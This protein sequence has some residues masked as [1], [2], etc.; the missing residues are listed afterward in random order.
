MKYDDVVTRFVNRKTLELSKGYGGATTQGLDAMQGALYKNNRIGL[1]EAA[2]TGSKYKSSKGTRYTYDNL[3]DGVSHIH[4]RQGRRAAQA[5]MRQQLN[6]FKT[7]RNIG[8]AITAGAL[9]VGAARAL[10]KRFK[11]PKQEQQQA[12]SL[13]RD[14]IYQ[15]NGQYDYDLDAKKSKEA[16][17]LGRKV[18]LHGLGVVGGSA[19]TGHTAA[20][21]LRNADRARIAKNWGPLRRDAFK[22]IIKNN[23]R[24]GVAATIA[25]PVIAGLT[26]HQFVKFLKR[27]SDL[28]KQLVKD[29]VLIPRKNKSEQY[30]QALSLGHQELSLNFDRVLKIG[31]I[32]GR[33][34]GRV[35]GRFAG[36]ARQAV[37]Q[38]GSTLQGAGQA[39]GQFASRAAAAGQKAFANSATP[40]AP[41][42]AYQRVRQASLARKTNQIANASAQ[43]QAFATHQA[44]RAKRLALRKHLNQNAYG[45]N[46]G[47][48]AVRGAVY[49]GVKM[50]AKAAIG[51]GK[52]FAKSGAAKNFKQA[53]ILGTG[54]GVG[55]MAA[56][57]RSDNPIDEI[58]NNSGYKIR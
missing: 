51:T 5:H 22:S 42:Y 8:L 20:F 52:Y 4:R 14:N 48:K 44:T 50:G 49:S 45:I 27:N 3:D 15:M 54:V 17:K 35:V 13:E 11:K 57:R 18:V 28:E 33:K 32:A 10:Y 29:G 38:A 1:A 16:D 41:Q 39:A 55:A 26:L 9:G 7:Q 58:D 21:A 40:S 34:I 24:A 46:K 36:Q 47:F 25:T 19:A 6:R 31:R 37:G 30:H 43:K 23:A 2:H 53:A 56:R 12:L